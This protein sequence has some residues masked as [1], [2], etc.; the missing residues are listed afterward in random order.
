MIK[1]DSS[2]NEIR[3]SGRFA[4]LLIRLSRFLS[5]LRRKYLQWRKRPQWSEEAS[6]IAYS[7]A[8][9]SVTP[10]ELRGAVFEIYEYPGKFHEVIGDLLQKANR[11]Q[12]ALAVA[13]LTDI[14][15]GEPLEEAIA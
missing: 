3:I 13:V 11:R 1:F 6:L 14:G 4:T 5:R 7:S 8:A 15:I 12:V 10:G 9:T 2:T